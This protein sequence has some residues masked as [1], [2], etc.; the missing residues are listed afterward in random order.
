MLMTLRKKKALILV[1]ASKGHSG[2]E[3][4]KLKQSACFTAGCPPRKEA[5]MLLWKLGTSPTGRCF[6]ITFVAAVLQEDNMGDWKCSHQQFC[7]SH[8]YCC[9]MSG[10]LPLQKQIAGLLPHRNTCL[11]LQSIN[12]GRLQFGMRSWPEEALLSVT[13]PPGFHR[14]GLKGDMLHSEL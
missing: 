9:S 6:R 2:H 5:D 7:F 11:Q 1:A 3:T 8:C 14:T 13:L 4:A 12:W 10:A